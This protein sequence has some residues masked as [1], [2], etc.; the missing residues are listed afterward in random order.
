LNSPF[1]ILKFRPL[2]RHQRRKKTLIDKFPCKIRIY[3]LSPVLAQNVDFGC[4]SE[5]VR[6]KFSKHSIEIS[7]IIL[8]E[9]VNYNVRIQLSETVHIIFIS[10]YFWCSLLNGACPESVNRDLSLLVLEQCWQ[11][12]VKVTT[13]DTPLLTMINDAPCVNEF[14]L[15]LDDA[16]NL[17]ELYIKARGYTNFLHIR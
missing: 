4:T 11:L 15:L 16:A 5:L 9:S 10:L 1:W 3:L 14:L 7:S 2:I 13:G 8:R 6:S 17:F 12:G